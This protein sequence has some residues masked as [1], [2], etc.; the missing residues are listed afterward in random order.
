MRPR[1]PGTGLHVI[2]LFIYVILIIYC[3]SMLLTLDSFIATPRNARLDEADFGEYVVIESLQELRAASRSGDLSCVEWVELLDCN[4]LDVTKTERS[5][6]CTEVISGASTAGFCRFRNR[7]SGE[8]VRVLPRRCNSAYGEFS[9]ASLVEDLSNDLYIPLSTMDSL[10]QIGF[11]NLD[12]VAW[13][14]MGQCNS[15]VDRVRELDKDCSEEVEDRS[16][17]FC[18]FKVRESD[19]LLRVQG[20]AC[21]T[22]VVKF[23]CADLLTTPNTTDYVEL[24]HLRSLHRDDDRLQFSC[25]GF[26]SMYMNGAR[27]FH[28]DKNCE[29]PLRP[30][31]AGYCSVRDSRGANY[32]LVL[33]QDVVYETCDDLLALV[34]SPEVIANRITSKKHFKRLSSEIG[35]RCVGFRALDEYRESRVVRKDLECGSRLTLPSDG[36]C[37]YQNL[38]SG[39]V[40]RLY[41]NDTQWRNEGSCASVLDWFWNSM[42]MVLT[43]NDTVALFES[44]PDLEC[45]SYR[46]TADCDPLQGRVYGRDRP[47][48]RQVREDRSGFCE[49]VDRKASIRY[50]VMP[51][52]CRSVFRFKCQYVPSLVSFAGKLKAVLPSFRSNASSTNTSE[53]AFTVSQNRGIVVC[54]HGKI[55]IQAYV[56]FKLL[57]SQNCKLP[58]EVWSYKGEIPESTPWRTFLNEAY[59]NITYRE[60]DMAIDESN[61]YLIK[62]YAMVF[63]SF[64]EV[65]MLDAD[66]YPVRNPTYLFS[67]KEYRKDGAMFW[68]DFWNAQSS[69]FPDL[70]TNSFW[71]NIIGIPYVEM[72]EGESG[73]IVIDRRRAKVQLDLIM[74]MLQNFDT[75]E[76]FIFGDKDWFRFAWLMV[77]KPFYMAQ[78]CGTAGLMRSKDDGFCGRTMVQFDPSGRVL[79]MHRNMAKLR[80]AEGRQYVWQ[81]IE[82]YKGAGYMKTRS[83]RDDCFEIHDVA[84]VLAVSEDPELKDLESRLLSYTSEGLIRFRDT[85]GILCLPDLEITT[86]EMLTTHVGERENILQFKIPAMDALMVHGNTEKNGHSAMANLSVSFGLLVRDTSNNGYT[87]NYMVDH[88]ERLAARFK[89]YHIVLLYESTISGYTIQVIDHW[90]SVNPRVRAVN[91]TAREQNGYI[92]LSSMRNQLLSEV[93]KRDDSGE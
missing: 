44:T 17:G 25:T 30:A 58:I 31:V 8:D 14:H 75:Y 77:E 13:R 91:A 3:I 9:C 38:L 73:Q 61:H 27:A 60:L 19:E 28:E 4:P 89:D 80:N 6:P 67:T 46:E 62:V 63:S 48:H 45:V 64:D 2:I 86:F 70:H 65:L 76:T 20:R 50:G 10:R 41:L 87:V 84:E 71:W 40:F 29:A 26:I 59:H 35:F 15:T 39:R 34:Y 83:I 92:R 42:Q 5:L 51:M 33:P 1:G 36:W 79:F 66:N 93:T 85:C 78:N 72:M 82:K 7:T 81:Y 16:M 74:F 32:K 90:T 43:W 37:E 68:P 57:A 52:A 56:L 18:E 24:A 47:C 88:I 53:E 21:G 49:Y 55:W 23:R 69:I 54:V 12:C 11:A 22:G